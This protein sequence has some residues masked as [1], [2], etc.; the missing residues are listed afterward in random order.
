M[1]HT[2]SALT[3]GVTSNGIGYVKYVQPPE[4]FE[5]EKGENVEVE[6]E[7]SCSVRFDNHRFFED[8]DYP[9]T[10]PIIWEP[11]DKKNNGRAKFDVV[12]F[13]FT[14]RS[15]A[16]QGTHSIKIG[17]GVLTKKRKKAKPKKAKAKRTASKK[18]KPSKGKK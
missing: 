9:G 14:L 6:V 10:G 11:K 17:T 15:Y 4:E 12:P 16:F 3:I 7:T 18:A 2:R 13:P 1:G 8:Q 5:R